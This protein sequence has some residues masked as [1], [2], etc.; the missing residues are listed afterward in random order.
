MFLILNFSF[1]SKTSNLIVKNNTNSAKIH[2][3]QINILYKIICP[4]REC[5]PK[6]KNNSYIGYTTK[7]LSRRLTY[8][9]S[10]NST[11]EQHLIKKKHNNSN[12]QLTSTDVRKILTDNTIIIYKNNNKKLLQILK[13]IG[14]KIKIKNIDKIAFNTGTNIL[15]IF[16]N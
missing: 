7:T 12:N 9:L 14:I 3:N 15:N 13:A 1:S 4:F 16:N 5:L 8:N 11:I 2:L 6:N 10:E